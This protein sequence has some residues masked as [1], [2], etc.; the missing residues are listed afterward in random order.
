MS[1]SKGMV[2]FIKQGYGHYVENTGTETLKLIILFNSP[3]YRSSVLPLAGLIR[4][5]AREEQ[6]SHQGS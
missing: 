5:S 6:V 2:S 4:L 1:F 3:V